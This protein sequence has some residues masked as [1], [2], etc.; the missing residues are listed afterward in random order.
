M[1]KIKFHFLFIIVLLSALGIMMTPIKFAEAETTTT[2]FP[3]EEA[4]IAAYVR[5]DNIENIDLEAF[6]NACDSIKELGENYI[7]GTI[8]IE[9]FLGFN[10]P[11]IYV[12]ADGWIVAYYLKT[13]E[14]SRIMQWKGYAAGSINTTILKDAID[15]ITQMVGVTYSTP[16]KYYDFE[17][18]EAT[19]MTIVVDRN[20]FYVT[21]PGALYEA[22][23]G[24]ILKERCCSGFDCRTLKLTIDENIIYQTGL[25]CWFSCGAPFSYYGYY[26]L[27]M[28]P[29]N[30]THHIT[31]HN[32]C[33]DWSPT[34][35]VVTTLIYKN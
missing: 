9:N 25:G 23:Y 35:S 17:F 32:G 8:K 14:A 20:D 7:V 13:E 22:S 24:L 18:P 21:V 4:G 33:S 1:K 19:K 26:N 31:F 34:S 5:L 30:T 28:F 3:V 11:H 16:I 6:A 15:Y 10:Y 29:T 27:S 2:T 12:G